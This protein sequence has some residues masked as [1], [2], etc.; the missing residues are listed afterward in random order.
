LKLAAALVAQ[1]VLLGA[2][3]VSPPDQTLSYR[4][5][6]GVVQ[7]VR[8]ARVALPRPGSGAIA[9]SEAARGSYGSPIER[10][11]RPRWTEGHQ[12][13]L[14]MDDGSTQQVTQDGATFSAGDR[15]QVTPEGR[16]VRLGAAA[17]KPA[18]S[19]PSASTPSAPAPGTPTTIRTGT[20]TV[21]SASIVALPSSSAGAGSTAPASPTMAYRIKM[22]DGSTQSIV[23]AG[24]R[25][26]TGDRIQITR[27]GRLSRR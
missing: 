24:E 16:V 22:D 21:E 1:A 5:G 8:A 3:A 12:L 11:M 15:V 18:V 17:A 19:T 9:G 23:Q 10:I 25:F 4:P 14:R 13:T 26:Q 2:C 6:T 27:E 20:G 7:E